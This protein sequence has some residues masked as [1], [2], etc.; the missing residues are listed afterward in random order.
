MEQPLVIPAVMLATRVEQLGTLAVRVEAEVP[1]TLEVKVEVPATTVFKVEG[2]ATRGDQLVIRDTRVHQHTTR[3]N[4][5]VDTFLQ[6]RLLNIL[7]LLCNTPPLRERLVQ[8][9]RTTRLS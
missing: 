4:S 3:I 7:E 8:G 1:V 5:G 9:H 2:L 6:S